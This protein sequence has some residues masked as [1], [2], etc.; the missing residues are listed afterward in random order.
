LLTIVNKINQIHIK[1]FTI[2]KKGGKMER[3]IEKAR[4]GVILSEARFNKERLAELM[5]R[6]ALSDAELAEKAGV[7]RTM[8]FYLRKGKRQTASAE[9]VAKIAAALNTTTAY[10]LGQGENPPLQTMSDPIRHLS[11]SE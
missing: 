6:R 2:V 4:G 7:S 1:L 3:I 9:V 8:I 11:E 5:A 10:L